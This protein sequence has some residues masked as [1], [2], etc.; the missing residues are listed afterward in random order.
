[1]SIEMEGK[2][3]HLARQNIG[4]EYKAIGAASLTELRQLIEPMR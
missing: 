4:I 3:A 1:M 2:I